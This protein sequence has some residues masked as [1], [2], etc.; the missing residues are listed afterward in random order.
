MKNIPSQYNLIKK[1]S[2][3]LASSQL[4][5]P[6]SFQKNAITT[7]MVGTG[8]LA[9]A[10]TGLFAQ[11]LPHFNSH[12]VL[13]NTDQSIQLQKQLAAPNAK[14][15]AIVQKSK[16]TQ[17]G[18]I[19]LT[20]DP[21]L[22]QP[23][24][25]VGAADKIAFNAETQELQEE[26]KLSVF[27][28]YSAFIHTAA[29]LIYAPNDTD[30]LKPIAS[31]KV[32]FK[33]LVNQVNLTWSGHEL[34][35]LQLRQNDRLQYVLRAY[36]KNGRW[37][38]T[39][40]AFIT[41]VSAA[42]KAKSFETLQQVSDLS[43]QL[44]G[45]ETGLS[46][47][48]YWLKNSTF[49]Q[50]SLAIQN[51]PLQGSKIKIR[52]QNIKP[53]VQLTINGQVVPIDNQKRFLMEYLLPVGLF[54]FDLKSSSSQDEELAVSEVLEANVT[55]EYFVM[56]A[57]ADIN[58]A[59]NTYQGQIEAVT[60]EDYKR[61]NG[62]QTEARL[63][64]YLKGKIKG[65]YLLTAHADTLEK[66]AKDLL[67]GIF[68]ADRTDLFRRIDP[69]AYYPIYG[70]DSVTT[71]DVDSNGRLY[72]RLD[73]DKS[74]AIF[75]NIKTDL[76]SQNLSSYNRSL[77]GAKLQMRSLETNPYGDAY[78]QAKSFIAE[79]QTTPGRA[80]LLGTGGSLYYLPQTDIVSGSEQV[81]LEL[82]DKL[83]S[84]V[85]NSYDLKAGRDYQL[86][87]FQG[88]IILTRPLL[89]ITKDNN[90][91]QDI[92]LD[93]F[94]N[95]LVARYEYYPKQFDPNNMSVGFE[96]KKWLNDQLAIGANYV[97]E[98]RAGQDYEL[99]GTSL[100]Y[101][102]GTGTWIKSELAQSKSNIAPQFFSADGGLSFQQN[103]L[104]NANSSNQ[105]MAYSV[106]ARVNTQEMGV[107]QNP[108]KIATWAKQKDANFSSTHVTSSG[109]QQLDTGLEVLAMVSPNWQVL[110]S[111]KHIESSQNISNNSGTSATPKIQ[112]IETVD[113]QNLSAV[114]NYDSSS[115]VVAELEHIVLN[116]QTASVAKSETSEAGLV[117]LR[118]NKKIN[119]ELDVFASM[120]SS[121]AEKNY[122]SND[123]YTVGTKYLLNQE[124]SLA[125]EHTEG[126]RGAVT[127]ASADYKRT[128]SHSL[129]G[130]YVYSPSSYNSQNPADSLIASR[131]FNQ[132]QGWTLGQ[133]LQLTEHLRMNTETQIS[134]STQSKGLT[135]SIGLDVVPQQNWQFGTSYQK[136]S[137]KNSTG[138]SSAAISD[139]WTAF[140][141]QQIDRQ[142]VSFTGAYTDEKIE[143]S[144]K[145]EQR[146]DKTATVNE[147]KTVQLLTTNRLSYKLSDDWH[148]T[149]KLNYSNTEK[150]LSKARES[151]VNAKNQLAEL[152]DGSLGFAWSPIAERW[153]LLAK[154]AYLYDL[155]PI[156]QVSSNGSE[157]DQKSH[158]LSVEGIYELNKNWYLGAKLAKRQTSI[159]LERGQGDWFTNNATYAAAQV[160]Y[161]VSGRLTGKKNAN[162]LD[163]DALTTGW[164]LM[165][166]YRM[167]K[168][169]KDGVKK[170]VLVAVEKEITKNIRLGV[171]YNF[172]D[173]SADLSQLSYKSKGY[174][175]N[176][177]THF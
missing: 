105:G 102:A 156:S 120:Q 109:K 44:K 21:S 146:Q 121:F 19:W 81:T 15:K 132:Q 69:E 12:K 56:V 8:V 101:Q 135:N 5:V 174:F 103:S 136:G 13:T 140:S 23:S 104:S 106:E 153:N 173:F 57:M 159:R 53:G 86:D 4:N 172:T 58:Y 37:D 55:G 107:S 1:K 30:R 138:N 10:S 48:E 176:L 166:E 130:S 113:K 95:V 92:E 42:D 137:V 168:T 34:K 11:D 32:P 29:V 33:S 112:K 119:P 91:I 63:A 31:L 129:Y 114:W 77:Y 75:G 143:W 94:N 163:K 161:K 73:W 76:V 43:T 27:S 155:A 88:R 50:S 167:L 26:I 59:N 133:R 66:E 68:K 122:S 142:S 71:R 54:Q 65:Q 126:D 96:V 46:L 162:P 7:S 2:Q 131:T 79:Q 116:N 144:S 45:K 72:I 171:G 169:E 24:L 67:K 47:E 115:T 17:I 100:A 98:N 111:A 38:E 97:K 118:V 52:G 83:S 147:S 49:G 28:N 78:F 151:A 149:S 18:R 125:L 175:I 128:D 22:L 16:L 80:Q 64:F 41:L 141:S 25:T 110:A 35:A 158:I 152:M 39:K 93:G 61:F 6:A 154:Y 157:F 134:E 51:I 160:R 74:N 82:R 108:V 14:N 117:G 165:A 20:E 164:A 150:Q 90:P 60:P 36:D 84:R 124:S 123:A 70:D 177:V 145:L 40:P 170:G 139:S 87:E 3:K 99:A 85:I 62:A 127:T 89:Q 148:M 9:L